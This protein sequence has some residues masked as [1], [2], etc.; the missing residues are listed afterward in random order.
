MGA[1]RD[2]WRGADYAAR[3]GGGDRR[4]VSDLGA[5]AEGWFVNILNPKPSLF[6]LSIFPQFLDSGGDFLAQ[7]ALLAGIHAAISA[8]WFSFVVVSIDRM[9][10][11]LRM[12]LVWRG[13]RGVTGVILIG[14]AARLA[15]V[16]LAR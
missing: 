6:Y 5:F 8:A 14:L 15:M 9:R 3:R 7:G 11:W 4:K 16:K 12:P 1:L 2:A 10:A 13:V